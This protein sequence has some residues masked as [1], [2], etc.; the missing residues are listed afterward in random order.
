MVWLKIQAFDFRILLR[1][2]GQNRSVPS[3]LVYS[4]SVGRF[5]SRIFR[6]RVLDR[7]AASAHEPPVH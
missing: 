4:H 1:Q 6:E 2:Q 7:P 3:W 5:T